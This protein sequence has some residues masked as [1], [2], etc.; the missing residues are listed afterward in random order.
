VRIGAVLA[1]GLAACSSTTSLLVEASLDVDDPTASPFTVSVFSPQRALVDRMT[2]PAARFPGRLYI[3]LPGAPAEEIRVVLARPLAPPWLGG[4][5]A[6]IAPGEQ[7]PLQVVL[8]RS[9]ADRDGDGVP[10][11]IDNC[12]SVLNPDQASASGGAG[13]ACANSDGGLDGALD[14]GPVDAAPDGPL[15]GVYAFVPSF[16]PHQSLH[17]GGHDPAPATMT[18]SYNGDSA[19]CSHDNGAS[20]A[21][22][23]SANAI[24][25][26]PTDFNQQ[27]TLAVKLSK[28]GV[29]DFVYRFVPSQA[30]AGLH[31]W[32]CDV[33][34]K[35]NETASE[36]SARLA[37]N[38]TICV[39]A[40]VEIDDAVMHN[41]DAGMHI[42]TTGIFL[43]DT[44]STGLK[45][46]GTESNRPTF[47]NP[48]SGGDQ[49][50]FVATSAA[51]HDTVFANL[52]LQSV[53]GNPISF[54][55]NGGNNVFSYVDVTVFGGCCDDA[56][57]FGGGTNTL[58][59]VVIDV[60]GSGN[61]PALHL[62]G[63][64]S[65]T[66]TA[67]RIIGR[68][69]TLG[70][71]VE[72]SALELRGVAVDNVFAS[73][74]TT[75]LPTV[76]LSSNSTFT[77][78]PG[79]TFDGATLQSSITSANWIGVDVAGTSSATINN[80]LV[81]GD[82][83]A[84]NASGGSTVTLSGATLTTLGT[85]VQLNASQLTVDNTQVKRLDAPGASGPAVQLFGTNII[86]SSQ[87]GDHFCDQ[88]LA[89]SNKFTT[90]IAKDTASSASYSGT[91]VLSKQAAMGMID[92]CP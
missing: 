68:D 16:P 28:A 51:V 74:G 49:G 12:P 81:A 75:F 69:D 65:V 80:T 43:G 33:V 45:V 53:D 62:F 44:N 46:L 7:T 20:Y 50:V 86:D 36:F 25:F 58:Y 31:F 70:V 10:D 6:T 48:D 30:L 3:E 37:M 42:Y 71:N 72:G 22:C 26:T 13:D 67:G 24:V 18:F 27:H 87:N 76:S 85:G 38:K 47:K 4:S 79:T 8:S 64:A 83:I 29:S 21:A 56:V 23:D 55:N 82:T 73:N 77:I 19:V 34:V 9:T 57:H 66:M 54:E 89:G 63:S 35:A 5:E 14:A 15:G 60:H 1:L 84:V 11:A 78:G 88:N 59:N 32:D 90:N 91:F 39:A 2:M 40:S 61:T 17:Y 92:Q 52:R 41:D